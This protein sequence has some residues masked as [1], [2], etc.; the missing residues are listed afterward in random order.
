MRLDATLSTI[1]QGGSEKAVS[2]M[3]CCMQTSVSRT[4]ALQAPREEPYHFRTAHT[5]DAEDGTSKG[6][7]LPLGAGNPLEHSGFFSASVCGLRH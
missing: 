3:K 1:R 7:W 5:L 2:C 4:S 6:F